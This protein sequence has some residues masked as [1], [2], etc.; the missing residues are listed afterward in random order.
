MM[1]TPSDPSAH[2]RHRLG[3]NK[4]LVRS[5]HCFIPFLQ[6][7]AILFERHLSDNHLT[8]VT[9]QHNTALRMQYDHLGQ[10]Q[11]IY[12]R[13]RNKRLGK[14]PG[15][16]RDDNTLHSA[17]SQAF[18]TSQQITPLTRL[19]TIVTGRNATDAAAPDGR[20]QEAEK[21]TAKRILQIK[22]RVS[23]PNNF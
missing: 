6:L 7:C 17:T 11:M 8:L 5:N 23:T 16:K 1:I 15:R 18:Q 21:C 20:F 3:P 10:Q 12:K 13:Q 2:S 19:K 9:M 14:R 22:N 4:R